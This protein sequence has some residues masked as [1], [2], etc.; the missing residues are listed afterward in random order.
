MDKRATLAT[1]RYDR[2]MHAR[3]TL[4]QGQSPAAAASAASRAAAAPRG[5]LSAADVLA[6]QRAA[7]NRATTRYLQRAIIAINGEGDSDASQRATQACL[8]NLRHTKQGKDFADGGARGAVVGPEIRQA[9]PSDLSRLLGSDDESIYVLAH[10]SRYNASIADMSPAHL[11]GWLRARFRRRAAFTGKIKLVSCHSGADRSHQ[12]PGDA[13]KRVYDFDRSYAQELA[14]A[15]APRSD[16][17]R[18]RPSSV[19]GIV[20]IGWVDEFTG[21]ITAIN[22]EAYDLATS[23]MATNSDVGA[24]AAAG[25]KA[26]PFTETG[27]AMTRGLELRAEFGT[28]VH[29]EVGDP[30]YRDDSAAPAALHFG[31]GNWGKRSFEVG[32]GDEL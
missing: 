10:G 3:A 6:L 7:G 5:R 4:P 21:S 2:A 9:L 29:V 26:N 16:T 24:L 15:L 12:K 8:W 23:G 11:A 18:F 22:K 17:D 25:K 31:K 20:G 32:S 27:D 1:E 14:I 13:A 19:E 30:G 28:P